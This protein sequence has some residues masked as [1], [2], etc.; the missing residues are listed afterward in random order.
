MEEGGT[1]SI[2]FCLSSAIDADPEPAYHFDAETRRVLN[3][4]LCESG[5]G[6]GFLFDADPDPQHCLQ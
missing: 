5:C 2:H 4:I 6:S 1:Y 3:L